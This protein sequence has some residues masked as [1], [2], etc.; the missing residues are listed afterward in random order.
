VW[1][2]SQA[3]R[4]PDIA[5]IEG[6]NVASTPAQKLQEFKWQPG[7]DKV[8]FKDEVLSYHA[9]VRAFS[10]VQPKSQV[11]KVVHGLC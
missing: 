8:E 11:V 10:V 9:E 4:Q 3:S 1:C 5:A 7:K 2:C 6:A